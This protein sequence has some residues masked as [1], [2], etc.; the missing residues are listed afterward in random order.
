MILENRIT[1]LRLQRSDLLPGFSS[2]PTRAPPRRIILKLRS[3]ARVLTRAQLP[4]PAPSTMLLGRGREAG[5]KTVE[6]LRRSLSVAVP[7]WVFVEGARDSN[8]WVTR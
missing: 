6:N 8:R 4:D 5:L 2:A 1:D 7:E 3:L